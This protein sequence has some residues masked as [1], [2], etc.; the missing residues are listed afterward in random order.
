MSEKVTFNSFGKDDLK[1]FFSMFVDHIYKEYK[2]EERLTTFTIE[3]CQQGS[4]LNVFNKTWSQFHSKRIP[5]I[6]ING[7]TIDLRLE[8]ELDLCVILELLGT[9]IDDDR[10]LIRLEGM[11]SSDVGPLAISVVGGGDAFCGLAPSG[12][13]CNVA[14]NPLTEPTITL[15]GYE[16]TQAATPEDRKTILLNFIK[17]RA[18]HGLGL[19]PEH[20]DLNSPLTDLGLDSLM[21]VELQTMVER[22]LKVKLPIVEL[23]KSVS[24]ERG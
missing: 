4:N 23:M 14:A 2:I 20:L 17:D 5:L 12:Y 7:S 15:S 16:D 3:L 21:G 22:D 19:S 6:T 8:N 18:A 13:W 10:A 24:K 9:D 1:S 11:F